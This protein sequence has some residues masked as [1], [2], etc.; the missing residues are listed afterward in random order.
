MWSFAI[1]LLGQIETAVTEIRA[2]DF[3]DLSAERRHFPDDVRAS[4]AAMNAIEDLKAMPDPP[5]ADEPVAV[6]KVICRTRLATVI[7]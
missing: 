3:A 5:P 4:T 6:G 7:K 2:R 1:R